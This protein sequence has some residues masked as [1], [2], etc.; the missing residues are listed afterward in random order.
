VLA[1][2]ANPTVHISDGHSATD[3]EAQMFVEVPAGT[4]I[5]AI[6]P[7][8]E[9]ATRDLF[10]AFDGYTLPNEAYEEW[11]KRLVERKLIF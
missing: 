8:V 2:W 11:V 7:Y 3:S 4:P 6:A 1:G 10:L 9:Q 5:S